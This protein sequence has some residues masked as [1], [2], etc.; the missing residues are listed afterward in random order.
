MTWFKIVAF[1]LPAIIAIGGLYSS[2]A[3]KPKL[4]H[5]IS[6]LIII[7][8][9]VGI[10]L[11]LKD[12]HSKKQEQNKAEAAY[13]QIENL[14]NQNKELIAGKDQVVAQNKELLGKI[15]KYQKDLREKE[16]KI[17][18]LEK[19]AKMSARGVTSIYSFNG[20]KRETSGGNIKGVVGEE[21]GIFRQ[22]VDLEESR[23][24]PALIKLCEQQIKKTPDWLTPYFYLGVAQANMGLK[25]EAIKNVKYVIDNAP[26][27]PEYKEAENILK[28]IEQ[29]P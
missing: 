17:E 24:Y 28:W 1:V 15:E 26:G 25:E 19:K 27:D 11:E 2:K 12:S 13:K 16:R 29:Q 20:V 3:D 21:L 7:G 9:I 22:M 23:K 6:I 14:N 4:V 8:M 10:A 18:E 5:T